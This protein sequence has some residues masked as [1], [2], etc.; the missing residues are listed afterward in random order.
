MCVIVME[1]N[2]S[3]TTPISGRKNRVTDNRKHGL[4]W[5]FSREL[6]VRKRPGLLL[7]TSFLIINIGLVI[8]MLLDNFFRLL[9]A[10]LKRFAVK[11]FSNLFAA[12][13]KTVTPSLNQERK[14]K[15]GIGV[16]GSSAGLT[17]NNCVRVE[18]EG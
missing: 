10:L 9:R 16:V 14:L 1:F 12:L 2:L 6:V 8:R 4:Q 13:V 5:S 17:C 11:S 15:T 3:S 18:L 7:L